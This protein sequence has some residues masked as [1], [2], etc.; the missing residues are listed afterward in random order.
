[1]LGQAKL[2]F[3]VTVPALPSRM[4]L[5]YAPFYCVGK[6][7]ENI[8]QGAPG[9]E[10]LSEGTQVIEFETNHISKTYEPGA[11]IGIVFKTIDAKSAV[12]PL[13]I[14]LQYIQFILPVQE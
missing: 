10:P 7:C 14:E 3:K 8:S 6:K 11:T 5:M 9:G 1:M 12:I 13:P 2:R 4:R